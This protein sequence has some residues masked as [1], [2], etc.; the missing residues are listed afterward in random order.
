MFRSLFCSWQIGV[1]TPGGI[2]T[3]TSTDLNRVPHANWATDACWRRGRDSNPR[4]VFLPPPVF[5]TGTIG[6]SDTSPDIFF[7]QGQQGSNLRHMV[8][9]TIALPTELYPCVICKNVMG[10]NFFDYFRINGKDPRFLSMAITICGLLSYKAVTP[11]FCRHTSIPTSLRTGYVE[12]P[13]S[14]A[15]VILGLPV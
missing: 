1:G 12:F 15:L 8:L 4:E 13:V 11:L 7:G 10:G 5:Q 3:H 14:T 2:R 6:L 9:E